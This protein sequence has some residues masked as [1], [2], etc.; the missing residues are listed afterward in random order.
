M[1]HEQDLYILL[2]LTALQNQHWTF[3]SLSKSLAISTSQLHLGLTRAEESQ[4]YRSSERRVIKQALGEFIIHGVKYSFPALPGK[5]VRG[6]PTSFAA[7]PL[8][9]QLLVEPENHIPVWPDPEGETLG[10]AIQP[11]H[12]GAPEAAKRD[13]RFY[14]LLA[15]V[16]AMREG[17]AREKSMVRHFIAKQLSYRDKFWE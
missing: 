9:D 5:I 16:D 7:H 2:K 3:A 6:M 15:M 13:L 1:L 17:R 11:L 14:E 4:L 10:Y 8:K 12:S